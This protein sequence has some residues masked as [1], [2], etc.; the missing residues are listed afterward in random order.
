MVTQ[1][2][3]PWN[4]LY[5][6]YFIVKKLRANFKISFMILTDVVSPFKLKIFSLK[7]S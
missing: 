3:F 7:I 6:D 2:K 5:D 4:L 1:G